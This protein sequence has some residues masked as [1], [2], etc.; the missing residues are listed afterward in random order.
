MREWRLERRHRRLETLYSRLVGFLGGELRLRANRR[1]E[2]DLVFHGIEDDDQR[3][4]HQHAVRHAEIVRV[5][6]GQ[7]LEQADRVVAHI[8]E[9]AGRHGRQLERKLESRLGQERA[10]RRRARVLPRA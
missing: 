1:D 9:H 8:A 7:V 2:T 6:V 5:D 3:R 10:Q 4:A